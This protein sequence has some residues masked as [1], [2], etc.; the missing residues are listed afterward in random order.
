MTDLRIIYL[1]PHGPIWG[2]VVDQLAS[3]HNFQP[4]LVV[5]ENSRLCGTLL[6][7]AD[8]FCS[9]DAR[10]LKFPKRFSD[11]PRPVLDGEVLADV[12][13]RLPIAYKMLSR[14]LLFPGNTTYE[15]K[16]W[17]IESLLEGWQVL[18]KKYRPDLI[19]G[20]SG[21]HRTFDYALEIVG[22]INHVPFIFPYH[23]LPFHN[24]ATV[25]D[26]DYE[27]FSLV[28]K[29]MDFLVGESSLSPRL[30]SR[31]AAM[32]RTYDQGKPTTL[33]LNSFF[34]DL[35]EGQK[36]MNRFP[37]AIRGLVSASKYAFGLN[38]GQRNDLKVLKIS[39]RRRGGF[40]VRFAS[41]IEYQHK[42]Y[43][44]TRAVRRARLWY[45]ENSEALSEGRPSVVFYASYQ[46]ERGSV[47]DG[48]FFFDNSLVMSL[49]ASAAPPD[50]DVFYREAPG[51]LYRDPILA[52]H[53][54]RQEDYEKIR[55]MNPRIKFLNHDLDSFNV[56]DK[57]NL[58]VTLNGTVIAESLA[59][60]TPVLQ[61]GKGWTQSAPEVYYASSQ[62]E[63]AEVF[64]RV[65]SGRHVRF[66]RFASFIALLEKEFGNQGIEG[67]FVNN[68]KLRAPGLSLFSEVPEESIVDS[69]C[70]RLLR[71][72]SLISSVNN[73]SGR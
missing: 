4:V 19:I 38:N 3:A 53:E 39:G 71:T 15:Q 72:Y 49:L 65:T 50:W 9:D 10:L 26:S 44:N 32:R 60:K 33:A 68:A 27:V 54:L 66:E 14:N 67:Y 35:G 57:C 24:L 64:E 43:T 29:N 6:P 61:I 34:S 47:P 48:R 46:P 41:K 58:I 28:A 25:V 55:E 8:F 62:D 37:K 45:R 18:F 23:D 63:I 2:H 17:Y 40:S 31:I 69:L 70:E 11:E 21:P 7:R 12:S 16:R 59:R 5:G 22:R 51:S 52:D 36:K 73:E 20:A 1:L 42:R 30:S 13:E 56:I